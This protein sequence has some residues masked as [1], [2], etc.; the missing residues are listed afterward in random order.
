MLDGV[1]STRIRIVQILHVFSYLPWAL[2]LVCEIL[3]FT[4]S[5]GA[6]SS[7]VPFG[8]YRHG[9]RKEGVTVELHVGFGLVGGPQHKKRNRDG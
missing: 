5:F 6:L 7:A 2:E 1:W 8:Q 9:R 4:R 3:M